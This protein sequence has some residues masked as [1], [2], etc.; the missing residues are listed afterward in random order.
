MKDDVCCICLDKQNYNSY[1]PYNC[2]HVMHS[3]CFEQWRKN[4]PLCKSG[5]N[6]KISHIIE[7]DNK[8]HYCKIRNITNT[9]PSKFGNDF[10]QIQFYCGT[11]FDVYK[12]EYFEVFINNKWI[13]GSNNLLNELKLNRIY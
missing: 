7:I 4:C 13:I 5:I 10:E 11:W 3:Q 9:K 8:K 2:N 6:T 1:K 12:G